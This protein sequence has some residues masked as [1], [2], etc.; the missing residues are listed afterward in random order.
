MAGEETVVRQVTVIDGRGGEPLRGAAVL[1][2]GDHIDAVGPESSV[3]WRPDARVIDGAGGYLLPGFIDC[4]VH[5]AGQFADR[6]RERA[7]PPVYT[8]LKNLAFL[9]RTLDAGVTSVRDAGGLDRG[10]KMAVE[11][12]LIAGPRMQ[13]AVTMLSITG[14]HNDPYLPALDM[15]GRF[16]RVPDG[17]CD[18]PDGVLRKV[19]EVL[20]AGAEVIKVA[21]S[22][23]GL[24]PLDDPRDA[25]FNADEL[26]VIVREAAAH[27]GVRAMAHAHGADG[28]KNA[29]RAGFH[30]IEH[31]SYLDDEAIALMRARG[32]FLVPTLSAP[33]WILEYAHSG[34]HR[35]PDYVVRKIETGILAAHRESVRRAY[36][37]GVPIAMGTDSG[38]GPHGRNL[39]ELQLLVEMGMSPMEAIVAATAQAAGCL[40]WAD[41]VGTIEVGKWADLVLVRRDPLQDIATLQEAENIRLVLKGGEVVGGVDRIRPPESGDGGRE[42]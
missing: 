40:G 16:E 15:T 41:R 5:L 17:V 31:G 38:V 21:T 3:R 42:A 22:G 13:L 8:V 2:R 23:G 33:Y 19:R 11:E 10:T 6:E 4:H 25:H 9:Q 28:I 36:E 35:L 32:V 34:G 29:V 1:I 24:S 18:G 39:L 27:G 12:G 20:R 14:G 26:A 37:A 7:W 30:S